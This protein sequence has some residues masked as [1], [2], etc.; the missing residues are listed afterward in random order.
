MRLLNAIRFKMTEAALDYIREAYPSVLKH[1]ICTNQEAYTKISSSQGVDLNE[2]LDLLT[3]EIPDKFKL[4]VLS[5]TNHTIS[6]V[7]KQYSVSVCEYILQNNYAES[8]FESL[9][10]KYEDLPRKVQQAFLPHAAAE[11]GRISDCPENVSTQLIKEL[12][13]WPGNPHL[14]N[15]ELLAAVIPQ[16]TP[17]EI[18]IYVEQLGAVEYKAIFEMDKRPTFPID[19]TSEILLPAFQTAGWISDYATDSR[20]PN[21]YKI[22]RKNVKRA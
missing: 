14:H 7:D 8:D 16:L 12:L 9:A 15:L 6:I 18:E 11:I 3:W 13:Q 2:L 1:Y 21:F 19:E 4:A 10:K 17:Q 22:I 20:R 5:N